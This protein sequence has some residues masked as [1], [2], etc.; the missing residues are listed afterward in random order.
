MNKMLLPIMAIFILIFSMQAGAISETPGWSTTCYNTT[1]LLKTANI[2]DTTDGSCIL[3]AKQIVKCN[4]GCDTMKNIC[5]KWPAN[6]IPGEYFLLFEVLAVV[7]FGYSAFRIDSPSSDTGLF[8]IITSVL[9]MILFLTLSLQGNNVIDT[10]TGEGVSIV[11]V[12]WINYA[13]AG[14]SLIFTF[15]NVFKNLHREVEA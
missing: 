11:M 12:V 1:H 6:A 15:L 3:C 2:T 14:L 4:Y 7:L 5:W 10:T 8:E 13:L 9:A